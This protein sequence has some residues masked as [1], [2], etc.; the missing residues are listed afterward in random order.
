MII[1]TVKGIQRNFTKERKRKSG[2]SS[3]AVCYSW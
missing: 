2:K 3:K 1:Q